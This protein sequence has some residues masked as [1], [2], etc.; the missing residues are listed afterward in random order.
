MATTRPVSNSNTTSKSQGQ[1]SSRKHKLCNSQENSTGNHNCILP[2]IYISVLG[3]CYDFSIPTLMFMPCPYI[4]YSSALYPITH[5]PCVYLKTSMLYICDL[6]SY[7]KP[8]SSF[9][10]SIC[11]PCIYH[12]K[13]MFFDVTL[14]LDSFQ[15]F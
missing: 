4:H 10:L 8:Y 7:P 12:E 14:S 11:T 13:T 9:L 15:S 1:I 2:T 3:P 5:P 6:T